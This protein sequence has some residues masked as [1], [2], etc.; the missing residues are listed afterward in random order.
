MN[1]LGF[2]E[3]NLKV[4]FMT[5]PNFNDL[6]QSFTEEKSVECKNAGRE[7]PF[8]IRYPVFYWSILK[9]KPDLKC[10]HKISYCHDKLHFYIQ[11]VIF[12]KLE[13]CLWSY[14]VF[15]H[16]ISM[17]DAATYKFTD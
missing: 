1:A 16:K 17:N 5:K 12:C 11:Y 6:L 2:R 4:F 10:E 8:Y 15:S 14:C 9:K 7:S 13:N 3:M